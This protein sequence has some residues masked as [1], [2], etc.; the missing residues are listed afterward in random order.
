MR[1]QLR[2]TR[3]LPAPR[4]RAH[5]GARRRWRPR[6]A[7]GRK[8]ARR[9]IRKLTCSLLYRNVRSRRAVRGSGL[10]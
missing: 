10:G 7:S 8:Q 1:P 4:F 3:R 2:P 6:V 5:V 9:R